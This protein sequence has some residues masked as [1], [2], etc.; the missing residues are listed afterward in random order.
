MPYIS[1]IQRAVGVPILTLALSSILKNLYTNCKTITYKD[2]IPIGAA[3]VGIW[4]PGLIP[5]AYMPLPAH[6]PSSV[7]PTPGILQ[8]DPGFISV[9]TIAAAWYA[10]MIIGTDERFRYIPTQF[11]NSTLIRV[12]M[13]LHFRLD[14]KGLYIGITPA[15]PPIPTVLPWFGL[16]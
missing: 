5:G 14:I 1:V 7:I 12:A 16:H 8:L 3:F 4:S 2:C 13:E 10:S 6:P 15:I 9:F 11:I